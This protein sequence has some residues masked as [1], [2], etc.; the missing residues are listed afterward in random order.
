MDRRLLS[1]I[2]AKP[3]WKHSSTGCNLKERRNKLGEEAFDK[4]KHE[5]SSGGVLTYF[6]LGC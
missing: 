3:F 6:I 1:Q 2:F 5:I 4:I